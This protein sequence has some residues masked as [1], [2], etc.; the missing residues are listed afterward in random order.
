MKQL[1]GGY[2][3]RS[4]LKWFEM[5]SME[6]SIRKLFLENNRLWMKRRQIDEILFPNFVS[7]ENVL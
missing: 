2:M 6:R 7:P 1:K 4:S 3:D 5:L